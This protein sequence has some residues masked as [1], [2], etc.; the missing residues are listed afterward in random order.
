MYISTGLFGVDDDLSV[1]RQDILEDTVGSRVG[2]TEIKGSVLRMQI[3][4]TLFAGS[5]LVYFIFFKRRLVHVGLSL[6][7]DDG[8]LFY[9]VYRPKY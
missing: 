8:F 5:L 7:I 1:H 3:S 4:F 9:L 6:L 2:R